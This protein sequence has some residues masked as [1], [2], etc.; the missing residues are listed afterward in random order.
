MVRWVGPGVCWAEGHSRGGWGF[1]ASLPACLPATTVLPPRFPVNS[2]HCPIALPPAIFRLLQGPGPAGQ[3]LPGERAAGGRPALPRHARPPL[4][5]PAG[6]H[7]GGLAACIKLESC[8][9]AQSVLRGACHWVCV[10]PLS[11]TLAAA[12]AAVGLRSQRQLTLLPRSHIRPGLL[13]A[14]RQLP[15][16]RPA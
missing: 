6:G 9:V 13:H 2:L 4:G 10:V 12:S 14:G 1:P 15:P 8:A 7:Q 5:R 11:A 16:V 3:E